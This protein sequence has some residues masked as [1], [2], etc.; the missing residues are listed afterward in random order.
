MNFNEAIQ[1]FANSKGV[2]FETAAITYSRYVLLFANF[3]KKPLNK[4]DND[5]ILAYQYWMK[6][7]YSERTR[8]LYSVAL[9]EFFKF[10]NGRGWTKVSREEIS[11]N[12]VYKKQMPYVSQSEQKKI[13]GHTEG[14]SVRRLAVMILWLCGPRVTELINMRKEDVD[15]ISK[16]ATITNLKHHEHKSTKFIQ[17]DDETN[18][19][20]K[21]VITD[22]DSEWVFY[23]KQTQGHLTRRQIAR[24]FVEFREKMGI[25]KKIT[26]HSMRRG[27]IVDS[28]KVGVP[29]AVL[30]RQG[31][32]DS[33]DSLQKYTN[34]YVD[35]IKEISVE[36]LRKRKASADQKEVFEKVEEERVLK[37]I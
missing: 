30:Q 4:I 13:M 18:E 24:W 31:G 36:A 14:N 37:R 10:A 32:W 8:A 28:L 5:D 17:W 26:P 20:M 16:G 12:K 3:I 19:L 1:K 7:K 35:D 23:S 22:N 6:T 27:F 2:R 15:L 25:T 21:E 9:R 11:I 34:I 33:L 29:L